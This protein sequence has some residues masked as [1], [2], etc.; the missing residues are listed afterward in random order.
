MSIDQIVPPSVQRKEMHFFME[1]QKCNSSRIRFTLCWNYKLILSSYK[2]THQSN[3]QLYWR[4][5]PTSLFDKPARCHTVSPKST[6]KSSIFWMYSR[7][8]LDR[9]ITKEGSFA[10]RLDV[11]EILRGMNG[12]LVDSPFLHIRKW[13]QAVKFSLLGK[14]TSQ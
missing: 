5:S 2:L 14:V 6:T 10:G 7:Q 8:I 12:Y 3:E 13:K 11:M 4:K 1:E 9:N